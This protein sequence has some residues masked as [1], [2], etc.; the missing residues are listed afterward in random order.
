VKKVLR[1]ELHKRIVI[2]RKKNGLTQEQ[3]AEITNVTVR[4]IQ[5][6]ESGESAPRANTLKILAMALDINF[7]E[8]TTSNSDNEILTKSINVSAKL[9]EEDGKHFLQIL[10]LS[11]FSYLIIPFVHFLIP[12]YLLKKSKEQNLQI[13][14]FARKTIR[15]QIYWQVTFAF[16]L[17][18]T[19]MYNIISTQYSQKPYF[20]NYL[21]PFFIM[22]FVNAILIANSLLSIKKTDFSS[23]K[24]I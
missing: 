22:Y 5:R 18:F 19:L 10:C 6:I 4:T 15:A 20:I 14:F 12:I 23:E 7:D 16:L 3:L 9:R 2:A 17:L 13:I 8:L 21:W 1:M 11:C 24:R